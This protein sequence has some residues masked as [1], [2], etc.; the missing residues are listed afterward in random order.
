MKKMKIEATAKLEEK[1]DLADSSMEIIQW[2]E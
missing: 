1:V 2:E